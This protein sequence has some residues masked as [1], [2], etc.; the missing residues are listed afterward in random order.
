MS[1]F[2]WYEGCVRPGPKRLPRNIDVSYTPENDHGT[3]KALLGR[4]N[5]FLR[6]TEFGKFCVSFQGCR[7]IQVL[8][9]M[10]QWLKHVSRGWILYDYLGPCEAQSSTKRVTKGLQ[11]H[12]YTTSPLMVLRHMHKAIKY[13]SNIS[14][15]NQPLN[16]FNSEHTIHMKSIRI[17]IYIYVLQMYPF[18]PNLKTFQPF[19]PQVIPHSQHAW[20]FQTKDVAWTCQSLRQGNQL[21]TTHVPV[22][23]SSLVDGSTISSSIG[24][25]GWW[26]VEPT[27]PSEKYDRQIRQ[28]GSFPGIFGVNIQNVF[29]PPPRS[30][31]TSMF[32]LFS[33]YIS[34]I[35]RIVPYVYLHVT[36]AIVHL[37]TLTYCWWF[38]NHA[39]PGMYKTL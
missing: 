28:I 36:F 26:V 27:N 30:I 23:W 34:I 18:W 24:S 21:Q 35:Y 29:K 14:C 22:R 2:G 20:V 16:I 39:Q 7:S 3:W 12:T 15:T 10:G 13:K 4:E 19:I 11:A 33:W 25:T 37:K 5:T 9:E 31:L 17:Y 6:N 38:R 1:F 32:S 8:G